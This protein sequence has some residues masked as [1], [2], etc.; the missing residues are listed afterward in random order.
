MEGAS[1]DTVLRGSPCPAQKHRIRDPPPGSGLPPVSRLCPDMDSS[2][3]KVGVR[4]ESG[5]E[6]VLGPRAQVVFGGNSGLS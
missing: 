3:C 6:L 1:L 4:E 5:P 2:H